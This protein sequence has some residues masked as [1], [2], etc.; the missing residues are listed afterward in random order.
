MKTL[1]AK[2]EN[3]YLNV[4]LSVPR[5]CWR[6]HSLTYNVS[7][8]WNIHTEPPERYRDNDRVRAHSY[9]SQYEQHSAWIFYGAHWLTSACHTKAAPMT[10]S[11]QTI[12]IDGLR[13]GAENLLLLLLLF[14]FNILFCRLFFSP[15]RSLSSAISAFKNTRHWI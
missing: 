4:H 13:D 9:V 3:W 11:H 5:R 1:G 15:S 7:G 2:H 6:I 12:T 14:L 8:V 10:S